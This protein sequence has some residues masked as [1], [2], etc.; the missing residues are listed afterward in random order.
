MR[1]DLTMSS[2]ITGPPTRSVGGG[3]QTGNGCWRLSSSLSVTLSYS[4]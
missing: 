1:R 4:T 2:I 3:G